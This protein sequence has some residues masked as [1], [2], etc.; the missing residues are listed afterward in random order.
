MNK[1]LLKQLINNYVK[2]KGISKNELA[3]YLS[4]SAATLSNIENERW[5]LIKDEMALKIYNK[6][7]PKN[8]NIACTVGFNTI[9]KV[10]DQARAGSKM[11][12]IIG[13]TG[14][15]KTTALREY[16]YSNKNTYLVVCKKSMSPKQFFIQ[17][18]KSIG[19]NFTGTN[20]D[21][22]KRIATELN[23]K[24]NPLL[25][26]DEA[27]KL[28]H[29]I[30]LYLHDLRDYT[31]NNAGIILAGVDYF[32]KNILK[33]VNRNK[34]GMPEF[35]DRVSY[36]LEMPNATRQEIK[37]I[38]EINGLTNAEQVKNACRMDNYRKVFNYVEKEININEAI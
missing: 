5:H 10:C 26:I 3:T 21:I 7:A 18:L 23:S 19:V 36:W 33:A 6:L 24:K 4:V 37:Y 14:A 11:V 22:I 38:C 17:I 30:L 31:D 2:K 29:T 8:W 15:G 35:Y 32:K 9:I 16:N 1:Q 20:Y 28:S 27:G 25:I 34:E 12:G 13:F